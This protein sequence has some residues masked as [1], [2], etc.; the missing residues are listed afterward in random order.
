MRSDKAQQILADAI[1]RNARRAGGHL[2]TPMSLAATQALDTN[3]ADVS[4][5]PVVPG[6]T[7]LQNEAGH[8][9]FRVGYSMIG[10]DH[11]IG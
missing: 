7:T 9:V 6:N 10:G 4:A 3:V 1:Q 5:L 8:T 2:P 11:V